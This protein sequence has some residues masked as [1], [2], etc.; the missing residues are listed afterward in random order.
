MSLLYH[1]TFVITSK[2][3]TQEQTNFN[4]I[5]EAIEFIHANYKSQPQLEEVASRTA[6]SPYHFQRMFTDWAGVSP[7]KFLEY[8]TIANARKMLKDE[9]ATLFDTTI[10]TGLSGT[11]RLHDLFINIEGMTPGEYKNGGED[12]SIHYSFAESPF[13]QVLVASTNKGICHIAFADDE[14]PNVGSLVAG[15]VRRRSEGE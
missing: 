6:L 5:A 2:Y 11:G 10:E 3:M 4:R 8:I 14:V 13:G 9:G 15:V 7:K 1:Y 12:L